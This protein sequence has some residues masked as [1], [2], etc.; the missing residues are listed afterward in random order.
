MTFPAPCVVHLPMVM[1]AER[2][3]RLGCAINPLTW[4]DKEHAALMENFE[5][6]T[7]EVAGWYY[8]VSSRGWGEMD[9]VMAYAMAH[10]K[11]LLYH[12]LRWW[13]WDAPDYEAWIREAMDRYPEI[14]D[15]VVVNE[16]WSGGQPTVAY[17]EESY[18]LAREIRPDARLWYNGLL[19]DAHE[20]EQARRLVS[21]GM[22]DAVGLQFHHNLNTDLSVYIPL[23]EWL[24][25]NR[26]A[27]QV[28]ELDVEIP[29]TTEW[30]LTQQAYAYRNVV[31]LVTEYGGEGIRTWGTSDKYSWREAYYPLA[32]DGN[33]MPKPAWGVLVESR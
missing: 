4:E 13:W 10:Q 30:C 3:I 6:Y 17:I 2:R 18:R 27:W 32:F 9:E 12:P 21:E 7:P 23:L 8:V 16:G 22:A 5:M 20:Q 11:P 31:Q 29:N 28:T 14:K 33:A 26:V 24:N 1:R 25:V 19:F 15:W